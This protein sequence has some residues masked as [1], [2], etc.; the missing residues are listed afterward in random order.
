MSLTIR[1]EATAGGKHLGEFRILRDYFCRY[2]EFE[3]PPWGDWKAFREV[4]S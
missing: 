2:A 4:F 1:L 3:N